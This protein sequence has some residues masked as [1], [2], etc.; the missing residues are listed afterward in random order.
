M[1]N[2]AERLLGGHAFGTLTDEERHELFT[3]AL[4]DQEL[5][6]ALAD[7]EPLRELL[8]DRVVRNELLDALDRPSLVE[9]VRAALR[10]PATWADLAA[11]TAAVLVVVGATHLLWPRAVQAPR[12]AAARP[13]LLRALFDLP[14]Q[15]GIAADLHVEAERIT[16][17]VERDAQAIL[18]AQDRDGAMTQVFPQ[19][20]DVA[21]VAKGVTL[22]TARPSG[23]V[24]VRLVVFPL[25]IDPLTLDEGTLRT[26]PHPLTVIEWRPRTSPG[27]K[28]T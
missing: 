6:D 24:R 22:S 4:E 14:A 26:V 16:F 11:A 1:K 7:Q 27:G 12:M 8:A 21:R 18:A 3:A 13:A 2:P 15:R 20:G 25:E 10:R 5:F 17:R 28:T 19:P 23:A 9:R